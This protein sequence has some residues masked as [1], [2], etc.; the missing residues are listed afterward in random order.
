MGILNDDQP[1]TSTTCYH[2]AIM[3]C[4]D[5]K[6]EA[7]RKDMA[8]E[9][10]MT[11]SPIPD[12]DLVITTSE[13]IDLMQEVGYASKKTITQQAVESSETFEEPPFDIVSYFDS[14]PT[15]S[16]VQHDSRNTT[17][18]SE[19]WKSAL[20][21][22]RS[23][24]TTLK[25]TESVKE[26]D[27]TFSVLANKNSK[28]TT[29]LSWNA[30]TQSSLS[31][32]SGSYADFIFRFAAL[33]LFGYLIPVEVI[34]PWRNVRRSSNFI[35]PTEESVSTSYQ[36]SSRGRRNTSTNSNL[37]FREVIL[38]KSRRDKQYSLNEVNGEVDA[39]ESRIPV[40]KFATAYGFKNIQ[41][42]IQ[43][44][45]RNSTKERTST[46]IAKAKDGFSDYHYIEV[47]ACPSGCSNGGGQAG[48]LKRYGDQGFLKKESPAEKRDRLWKNH[49]ILDSR[50]SRSHKENP[51][52][53]SIFPP[54]GSTVG[55]HL[56]HDI[57]SNTNEK[58]SEELSFELPTLPFVSGP[59]EKESHQVFHTRYH[60]VPKLQLSVGAVSGVAISD[61]KW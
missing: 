14:L 45:K 54:L 9:Q 58:S 38:Y 40:L 49:M 10:L 61:T 39:D 51:L 15:A 52:V 46:S 43:K 57:L 33:Q 18:G 12:V 36:P 8:W 13:L 2:V 6:L 50:I 21:G 55:D 20:N 3:P 1:V 26:E 34:L 28:V 56:S 5:K 11:T 25:T 7:S 24:L 22:I 47:M 23:L 31:G 41:S 27:A 44:M 19:D 48:K 59:F 35:S 37:D 29:A 42:I 17:N 32:S 16:V 30:P 60:S 53:C 4:H